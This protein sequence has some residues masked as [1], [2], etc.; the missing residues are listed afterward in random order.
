MSLNDS[1]DKDSDLLKKKIGSEMKVYIKKAS[2]DYLE[3]LKAE[4]MK[5]FKSYYDE[6][7]TNV[8]TELNSQ[9][10]Q[11]KDLHDKLDQRGA[12]IAQLKEKVL[13]RIKV[14]IAEKE[15]KIDLLRKLKIISMLMTNVIN[16]KAKRKKNSLILQLARKNK[17]KKI[18]NVFKNLSI[19][20]P[21]NKYIEKMKAESKRKFEEFK[22]NQN[23]QKQDMIKLINQAKE[24][25][26]HENRKKVQVKLLLDQMILRGI[27]SLNMQAI[28]LSQNS[29]NGNFFFLF[30][31]YN[32][33]LL[34][35]I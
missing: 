16:K 35:L 10:T 32:L 7:N 28:S 11:Q 15:L 1:S 5:G 4:V 6:L 17:I 24:K 13:S 3:N 8:Q 26:K 19:Y 25:L 20:M 22:V 23:N 33:P 34:F 9:E 21:T 30:L 12:K 18:F 31:F 29:L 2:G 14:E 27:S